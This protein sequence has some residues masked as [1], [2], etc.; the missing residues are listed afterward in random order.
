MN[1]S[2]F[3]LQLTSDDPEL[4][5][6]FYR[7]KVGLPVR[8][9]MGPLSLAAA[10]ATIDFDHHHD[11]H[12]PAQEPSRYLLDLWVGDAKRERERLEAAGIAFSRKEGAEAWGGLIST[13]ADPD[14]N[15][16]Q[17]MQV[18]G[19]NGGLGEVT[20]FFL[21]IT[22]EDPPGMVA[23]YRDIIGLAPFP[24]VGPHGL[25]VCEGALLHFDTHD[26]T[27]GPVKEPSR[28]IIGLWVDSVAAERER[29]EAA[30]LRFFRREGVEFW[31]GVIA[32]FLD[33]D[34]NIIQ[35]IE[36][37]ASRATGS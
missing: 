17:V 25:R 22:T 20:G 4:L 5:H 23:F 34:G 35:L 10:G 13:F 32:S 37:D 3:Y 11:T 28:L 1:V 29:M 16:V 27:R 21:D 36:Y 18:P 24:D 7:D 12:G 31:G 26:A 2:N 33:P 6:G 19:G 15:L 8:E 9:N 14:G 30:G